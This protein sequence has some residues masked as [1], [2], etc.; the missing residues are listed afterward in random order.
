MSE[1]T[2]EAADPGEGDR[3]D[4]IEATQQEQGATLQRISEALARIVPGSRAESAERVE[5]RLDR[6]STVEEQVKAEL[7]RAKA[8]EKR[9]ADEAAA[10]GER[11]T[12]AQRVAR[13]EEKPPAAPVRRATKIL[14][15]GDGR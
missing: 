12:I 15:W 13:L 9:Q 14:G 6:P 2:T 10:K 1:P 3:L 7:A 4:R 5:A 11:E 8:E